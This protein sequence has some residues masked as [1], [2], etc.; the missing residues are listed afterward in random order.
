MFVLHNEDCLNILPSISSGSIDAIITDLPYGTTQNKW[1]SVIDLS[2]MWYETKRVLKPNGVFITTTD[3][4]FTSVLIMSDINYFKYKITWDKVNRKTGHLNA[5]IR[6]LKVCEDVC[7]FGYGKTTYNPQMTKGKAYIAVSS[8]RKTSNYGTQQDKIK[9]INE[10]M[11]YP[12]NLIS[13]PADERGTV[14]RIHPTQKPVALYEYLIR[15][16]TNESETILDICMGSGTTIE[17]A[18]RTNRNSI[19]IEK[20]DKIFNIASSRLNTLNR[21]YENDLY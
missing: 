5:K 17:A 2:A 13:I 18:E 1:D 21:K 15:T 16:F 19:G 10:G 6:P 11:N 8:G 7:I 9:T 4:P 3:E 12:L 20:D 14:G